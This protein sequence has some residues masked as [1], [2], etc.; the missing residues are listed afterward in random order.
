M[1]REGRNDFKLNLSPPSKKNQPNKKTHTR[2]PH[3]HFG[4]NSSEKVLKE[5]SDSN[6]RL[7]KAPI[8]PSL[9]N[10]SLPF[11]LFIAHATGA[12]HSHRQALIPNLY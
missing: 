6:H 1:F 2:N 10:H 5:I 12:Q 9:F 11:V 4:N 8:E 7:F 3:L